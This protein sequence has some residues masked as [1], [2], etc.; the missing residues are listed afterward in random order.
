MISDDARRSLRD[1]GLE[2]WQL[3][4][5]EPSVFDRAGTAQ[6]AAVEAVERASRAIERALRELDHSVRRRGAERAKVVVADDRV[7]ERVLLVHALRC[8]SR[9]DVV[10]DA[11]DG[12]E[13]LANCVVEQPDV[14]V[15]D[16]RLPTIS[17]LDVAA[18]LRIYAPRT[19]TI[20]LLDEHDPLFRS[21]PAV[22]DAIA[23][24]YGDRR[25]LVTL[26]A[27][28]AV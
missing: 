2:S 8:D 25:A 17:G 6:R 12:T 1:A 22:A 11:V 5:G 15:L 13:A 18:E 23:P 21:R 14:V 24:R 16:D 4:N 20:L 3:A 26:V 19:R 9:V 27:H 7:A 10:A 28:L